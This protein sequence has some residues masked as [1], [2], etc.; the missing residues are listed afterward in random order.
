MADP[1]FPPSLPVCRIDGYGY[2]SA[3]PF[4]RTNMDSGLARQRRRFVSTPANV[5]ATWRLTQTQLGTFESFVKNDLQAGVAWFMVPLPNGQG[6]T[7]VRARFTEA[8]QV[9]SAGS[10]QMFDVACKLET[11][12]FPVT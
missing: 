8:H 3:S 12:S 10:P 7:T 9:A 11:L 1:I 4:A 2:Q 5:T 6:L